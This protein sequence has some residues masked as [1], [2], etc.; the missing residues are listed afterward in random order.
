MNTIAIILIIIA[1]IMTFFIPQWLEIRN[2]SKWKRE[3][4]LKQE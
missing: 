3:Q 2:N 4:H 1:I